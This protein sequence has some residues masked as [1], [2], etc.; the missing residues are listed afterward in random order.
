MK[1]PTTTALLGFLALGSLAAF[2]L[3]AADQDQLAQQINTVAAQQFEM[4]VA[5]RDRDDKLKTA[6]AQGT[7][8]T[9]EMKV[10]RTKIG[11]LE[12]ELQTARMELQKLFEA[13]PAVQEEIKALQ[14]EKQRIK[15]LDSRRRALLQQRQAST[16]KQA[17]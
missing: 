4:Q 15:E 11:Q 17:E 5:N 13:L 12:R 9:P 14:Q 16:E 6:L 1:K 10:L 7:L 3:R 2:G 8:D